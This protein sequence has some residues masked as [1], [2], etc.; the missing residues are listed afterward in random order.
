M[1]YPDLHKL[2]SPPYIYIIIGLIFF[3]NGLISTCIGKVSARF[4]WVYRAE[5]PKQF[6]WLVAMNYLA[7]LGF[8]G[9]FMYLGTTVGYPP[10]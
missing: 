4:H 3:S 10:L 6:W 5:E 2:I 7:G 8:I 9:Y 1:E